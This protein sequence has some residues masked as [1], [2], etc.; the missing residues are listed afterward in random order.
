[1]LGEK[2][3]DTSILSVPSGDPPGTGPNHEIIFANSILKFSF[4]FL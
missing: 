2:F 4:I 1:M 3:D